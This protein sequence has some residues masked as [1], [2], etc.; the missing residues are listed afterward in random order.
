MTKTT[1]TKT[2]A[3]HKLTLTAGVQ[4]LASRPFAAR[5]RTVYPVTI[6]PVGAE[7]AGV[8]IDGLTYDEANRLLGAFNNGPMSFDGRVW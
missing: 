5:G 3:G 8:V 7:A 6:E 2:I 1:R 4:Y